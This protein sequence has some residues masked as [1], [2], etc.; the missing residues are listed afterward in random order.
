MQT[1]ISG[2]TLPLD[3]RPRSWRRAV[4]LGVFF[5]LVWPTFNLLIMTSV[6]IQ[7]DVFEVHRLQIAAFRLFSGFA[8]AYALVLFLQAMF[9][10]AL[11]EDRF[12]PQWL[13]HLVVVSG[14]RAFYEPLFAQP[15]LSDIPQPMAIPVVYIVLQ[16]T[17]YVVV[18]TQLIQRDHYLAAQVTLR[19]AQINLLRSQTNPHFLFNTLNLLA[20]EISRSP[21]NAQE[22]VYDLADLLRDSMRAAEREFT[23]LKE[24]LRLVTLYLTLQKKRFPDRLEFEIDA[25]EDCQGLSLPALLL[26]PI[27]ENVIKHV[28]AKS[29]RST[30]LSVRARA[31]GQ[32][33]MISVSDT[34]PMVGGSLRATGGL[35]IVE[36]TLA[37]HY[38]GRAVL[39]LK[40]SPDGGE[41][42]VTLPIERLGG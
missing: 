14:V 17:L 2:A 31:A 4:Y 34:G 36:E 3:V 37:L 24:E 21:S 18:K 40:S 10:S 12:W 32:N 20:S 42:T 8:L 7:L 13:L 9:P 16:V 11:A 28:V 22:I 26:Q 6:L 19:Q 15:A 30:H 1:E 23:T 39:Q 27:V 33:L 29:S 35:R 25:S 41:V 5:V 38:Q